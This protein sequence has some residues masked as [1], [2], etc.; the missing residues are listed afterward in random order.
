MILVQQPY[1]LL[2]LLIITTIVSKLLMVL[3]LV[4]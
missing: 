1:L 3:E 2:A 4:S